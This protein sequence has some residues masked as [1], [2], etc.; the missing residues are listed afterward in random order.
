MKTI[1]FNKL[2]RTDVLLFVAIIALFFFWRFEFWK[3]ALEGF[4]VAS[5]IIS[6]ANHISH[7]KDT[8]KFY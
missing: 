8:K 4:I 7:Y 3:G 1:F 6:M 2:V 5:F